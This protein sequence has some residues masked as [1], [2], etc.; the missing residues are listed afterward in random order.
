MF[1]VYKIFKIQELLGAKGFAL[2]PLG[3]SGR[4]PDPPASN[5]VVSPQTSIAGSAPEVSSHRKMLKS[6][7]YMILYIQ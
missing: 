1:K 2:D 7:S 6:M 3:D 5:N 4:P